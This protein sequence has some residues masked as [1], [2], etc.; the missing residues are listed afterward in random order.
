MSALTS[1]RLNQ[2][3]DSGTDTLR[4]AYLYRA[5]YQVRAR[6]TGGFQIVWTGGT[7]YIER[8]PG[9]GWI[10]D[11]GE[12]PFPVL[13]FVWDYVPDRIIDPGSSARHTSMG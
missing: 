3:L 9:A 5:P 2:S 11:R 4:T 7:E 10:V 1:Y 8:G 6:S 12:P 13:S